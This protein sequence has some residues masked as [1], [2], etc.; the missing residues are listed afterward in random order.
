VL[1]SFNQKKD[2]GSPWGGLTFDSAGNLYG[3]TSQG[4]AHDYGTVF[5]FTPGTDGNYTEHVLHSFD[6]GRRDG[7]NPFSGVTLDATGNL[8]G[9]TV[10]GGAYGNGTVFQLTPGTGGTWS[11]KVL[12]SFGANKDGNYP[13]GSLIFDRDGNLYGV[14]QIGGAY[15][16]GTVF[17]LSRG[18][19]GKWTEKVL[20][21][22]PDNR[23]DGAWVDAIIF[24][25]N[26]NLYGTSAGGGDHNAGTVFE[27]TP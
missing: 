2:G 5:R 14:T 26:G 18:T 24:D 21:N 16:F 1:H 23:N 7:V 17:R 8:Y 15:G 27:I 4:G 9:T 11:E 13:Q 3:T 6:V 22:F 12:H 19:N 25:A 20:H 10:N